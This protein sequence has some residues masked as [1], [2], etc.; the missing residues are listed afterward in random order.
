MV[1]S[2]SLLLM[3]WS[4]PVII[5]SKVL[6]YACGKKEELTCKVLYIFIPS[7][8]FI[9]K[10]ILNGIKPMPPVTL[11]ESMFSSVFDAWANL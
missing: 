1:V 5:K 11:L 10:L 4:T 7:I 2:Q 6:P 9:V 8:P 3:L